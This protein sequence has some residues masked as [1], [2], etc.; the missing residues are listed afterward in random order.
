VIEAPE[1][2]GEASDESSEVV[3][4]LGR[5]VQD[6]NLEL[7]EDLFAAAAQCSGGEA[8]H[9]GHGL[10]DHVVDLLVELLA[11]EARVADVE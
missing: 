2:E 4:G 11:G 8:D 9:V 10:V 6:L 7:V 1:P 5:A 3:R